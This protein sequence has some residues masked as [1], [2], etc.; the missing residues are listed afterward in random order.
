MEIVHYLVVMFLG[1]LFGSFGSVIF[2]RLGDLPTRKTLKGFLRGRSECRYCHH[3][4]HTKDLVPI[5]SFFSQKGKCR[6]CKKKL[7]WWYSILEIGTMIIFL[8]SYV[9]IGITNLPLLVF[10]AIGS[11]L[12]WII[13][14]YDFKTYELHLSS[15]LALL[16]LSFFGQRQMWYSLIETLRWMGIFFWLFLL[17]YL[18]AK[19]YVYIKYKT[20]AEGFWFGDVIMAGILWSLFPMFITFSSGRVRMY[21]LCIYIMMSCIM[22]IIL[23]VILLCNTSKLQPKDIPITQKTATVIPFLP[24]MI[25][26]FFCFL[27]RGNQLLA[28]LL[29]L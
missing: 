4:L 19:G 16:V 6:Y 21:T 2:F 20:N 22:G 7:S 9:I 1:L 25:L 14:L 28:F 3:T 27:F 26:A 18:L 17:I 13:L 10:V 23:Y 12:L 8:C 11:R 5:I 24:A 29:P 15:A